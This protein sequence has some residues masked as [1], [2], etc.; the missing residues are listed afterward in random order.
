MGTPYLGEIRIVSFGPRPPLPGHRNAGLRATVQLVSLLAAGCVATAP[1]PADTA[2]QTASTVKVDGSLP[3][4]PV[5]RRPT[6][7]LRRWSSAVRSHRVL[8]TNRRS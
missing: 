2:L 7:S 1:K 3:E 5:P 4:T 6:C 8:P